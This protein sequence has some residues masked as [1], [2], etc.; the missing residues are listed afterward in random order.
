MFTNV[1]KKAVAKHRKDVSKVPT[2]TML[3]QYATSGG[4]PGQSQFSREVENWLEEHDVLFLLEGLASH[5]LRTLPSD[6]VVEADKW[7]DGQKYSRAGGTKANQIPFTD[8][9]KVN[10]FALQQAPTNIPPTSPTKKDADAGDSFDP[11]LVDFANGG[12]QVRYAEGKWM[13]QETM[14][15]CLSR[16]PVGLKGQSLRA[17][18]YLVSCTATAGPQLAHIKH[19]HVV[20]TYGY[21]IEPDLVATVHP[22]MD[23][24]VGDE[25]QRCLEERHHVRC[26]QVLQIARD[27]LRGL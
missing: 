13:G 21:C 7:L 3:T 9:S 20:S 16:K 19:P 8:I 24:T 17:H 14:L 11:L 5:L 10:R 6:E 25:L 27:V 12:P 2:L 26:R 18:Q 22:T 15:M 23:R 4:K 1:V